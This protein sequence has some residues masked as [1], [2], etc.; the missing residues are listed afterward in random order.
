LFG[1]ADVD[2]GAQAMS[3]AWFFKYRSFEVFH[4][5]V[6]FQYRVQVDPKLRG[7]EYIEVIV[8]IDDEET[9]VERF[10]TASEGDEWKEAYFVF[11]D[12][13]D[14]AR[15]R[16]AFGGY[17]V[18]PAKKEGSIQFTNILVTGLSI[19]RFPTL[20]E[21]DP[22]LQLPLRECEGLCTS[23]DDCAG[24]LLCFLD[25]NDEDVPGCYGEGQTRSTFCY[26]EGLLT[27]GDKDKPISAFP[28]G[29]CEGYC[30]KDDDCAE[31]LRCFQRRGTE[32]VPGCSG[33]GDRGEDYCYLESLFKA[34]DNGKPSSVFPL[35]ECQGDCDKN[36]DCLGGLQCFKR[37]NKE[38]VP[39]CP[40]VGEDGTHYCFREDLKYVGDNGSPVD[41]FPLRLCEGDCDSDLD[42]AGAL[43]CF[44]RE[45][46]EVVP[47]CPGA[48]RTKKDYCFDDGSTAMVAPPS[49]VPDP[50]AGVTYLPGDLRIDLFEYV[51]FVFSSCYQVV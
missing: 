16:L 45:S 28:L 27:M 31:G 26:S 49:D 37:P 20:N 7:D 22:G 30:K 24:S 15:H 5:Q 11:Y 36:S 6:S 17:A 14:F 32:Q 42:C 48:G 21:G 23:H 38:I 50:P 33:I 13:P 29:E 34:D 4:V 18:A 39:G 10:D 51:H 40:G 47:G 44:Q 25:R 3:A 35:G 46:T 12:I 9:L 19:N 2:G 8:A 1:G 43:K 41:I